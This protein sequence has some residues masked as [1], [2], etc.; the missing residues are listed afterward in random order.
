MMLYILD[1]KAIFFLPPVKSLISCD[2]VPS[3]AYMSL[4]TSVE[5][6]SLVLPSCWRIFCTHTVEWDFLL[7]P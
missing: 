2:S 7:G 6:Q 3:A 4:Q 5:F 1:I